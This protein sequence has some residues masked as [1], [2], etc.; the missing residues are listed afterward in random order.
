M[1]MTFSISSGTGASLPFCGVASRDVT[2]LCIVYSL[3]RSSLRARARHR[4]RAA[5]VGPL[6]PPPG[7]GTP[8]LEER[9]RAGDRRQPERERPVRQ[10]GDD[11]EAAVPAESDERADHAAVDAGDPAG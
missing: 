6:F 8:K 9:D 11:R 4:G 2:L 3:G 5:A 7:D 10:D 1:M